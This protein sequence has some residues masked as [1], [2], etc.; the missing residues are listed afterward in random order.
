M[1]T[2]TFSLA[3]V[4]AKLKPL[5]RDLSFVPLLTHLGRD[6]SIWIDGRSYVFHMSPGLALISS[7]LSES[8]SVYAIQLCW[9]PLP[10]SDGN[11][12]LMVRFLLLEKT[13]AMESG[14]AFGV[15]AWYVQDI[16]FEQGGGHS[17]VLDVV[18]NELRAL[19]VHPDSVLIQNHPDFEN[20]VTEAVNGWIGYEIRANELLNER[21]EKLRKHFPVEFQQEV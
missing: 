9:V 11:L 19:S 4:L 8:S 18:S 15:E 12:H 14:D 21:L 10:I 1:S 3:G 16:H 17:S 13:A 6:Q 20:T 2:S 5:V 7:N